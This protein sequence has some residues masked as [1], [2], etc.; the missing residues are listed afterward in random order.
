M[1]RRSDMKKSR[2]GWR[3]SRIRSGE[4]VNPMN[5]ISN[6]SDAMLVLAVGIM[7]ALVLHWNVDLE[8]KNQEAQKEQK[9]QEQVVSFQ[10]D[11]LENQDKV[12]DSAQQAG[13]VYYDAESDTYYIVGGDGQTQTMDG[14]G[15]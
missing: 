11:E 9:E 15:Q 12:P 10:D 4:D 5:Y 3:G 2:S 7:V 1:A 6:L 8:A 13:K 14:S